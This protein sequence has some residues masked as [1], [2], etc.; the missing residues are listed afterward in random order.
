MTDE[1][2]TVEGQTEGWQTKSLGYQAAFCLP[3]GLNVGKF[4]PPESARGY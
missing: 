4:L 1:I 2:A 3:E